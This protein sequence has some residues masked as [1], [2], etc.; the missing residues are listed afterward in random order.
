MCKSLEDRQKKKEKK[1]INFYFRYGKHVSY[2][3]SELKVVLQ[4]QAHDR[5]TQ[6]MNNF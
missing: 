6:K 3:L 2:N 5:V 1:E 4:R